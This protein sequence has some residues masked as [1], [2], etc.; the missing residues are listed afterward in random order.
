MNLLTNIIAAAE[1]AMDAPNKPR[2]VLLADDQAFTRL[3]VGKVLRQTMDCTVLEAQDGEEAIALCQSGNPDL[4]TPHRF[5]S[6]L[7][8]AVSGIPLL[9]AI[10]MSS[11][12]SA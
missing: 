2:K 10:G 7:P 6:G 5:A 8:I 3:F 12:P 11:V 4:V 9:V 1:P